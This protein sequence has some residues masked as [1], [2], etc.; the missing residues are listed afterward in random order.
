MYLYSVNCYSVPKC[1]EYTVGTYYKK[2]NIPCSVR[3]LYYRVVIKSYR[4]NYSQ[5]FIALMITDV[6]GDPHVL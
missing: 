1:V 4:S 5:R 2:C 6:F 3:L